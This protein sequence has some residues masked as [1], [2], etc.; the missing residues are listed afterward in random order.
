L[1]DTP[2]TQ[3]PKGWPAA[4]TSSMSN[5]KAACLRS[6]AVGKDGPVHLRLV[7]YYDTQS[8]HP[9]ASFIELDPAGPTDVTAGDLLAVSLL[10]IAMPPVAV[11]RLL[12]HCGH[13]LEV[14][15]ALQT[16][17]DRELYMAD[18][19]TLVQMER[20]TEAVLRA[21][22]DGTTGQADARALAIAL[23][24]RK[25]PDLFPVTDPSVSAFLGLGTSPDDRITWQVMWHVLGD[26]EVLNAIDALKDDVERETAGRVMAESSR[27]RVLF[28]TLATYLSASSP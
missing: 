7:D 21:V 1:E 18:K 6:L 23:C 25:R 9:G 15:N 20:L 2:W 26:R 12:G 4:S 22:H 27:A 17:P 28:A 13:R 11:R 3:V 24:A 5:A 16:M 14:L 19:Q 8:N 10:G